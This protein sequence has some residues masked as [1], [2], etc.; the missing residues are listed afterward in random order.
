M[1]LVDLLRKQISELEFR[2][3]AI[4]HLILTNGVPSGDEKSLITG[5]VGEVV[6]Q[7]DGAKN[8]ILKTASSALLKASKAIGPN[9]AA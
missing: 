9:D 2:V 5:I 7:I 4:E 3:S 6:G 8:N 1:D